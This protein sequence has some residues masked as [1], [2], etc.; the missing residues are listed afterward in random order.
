MVG[1]DPKKIP[2][3]DPPMQ[4]KQYYMIINSRLIYVQYVKHDNKF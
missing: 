2:T 1:F 4:I 3:M